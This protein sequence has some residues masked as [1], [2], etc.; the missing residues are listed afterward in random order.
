M[1]QVID[2]LS[3]M[4][5]TREDFRDIYADL[6]ILQD[7]ELLFSMPHTD[8]DFLTRHLPSK[9]WRMNNLYTIVDKFGTKIKFKMRRAQHIVYAESLRHPRLIILKSRQQGISTFW[10]I[11]FF[12][13]LITIKNLSIGLM[14]QGIDEAST[15]LD[16]TKILWSELDE[17]VKSFLGLS[18]VADN[19]KTF[20]LSN[21]S[22]IF[23][24]TSFRSTTL[25][26]LHISEMGKIANKFPEKAKETKTGTLQAIAQGNTAAIES[27]A[28]GDNLFKDMWDTAVTITDELSLK[29]FKPVFLSWLGDPD[30]RVKE[31]QTVTKIAQKYFDKLKEEHDIELDTEQKNFW[32]VQYRELGDR[33]YQEYP[34]TDIEAFMATKSGTY[35]AQLYMENV[36]KYKRK[37]KFAELYDPNLIIQVS[38]D[39]GMNDT[40]VLTI[41]QTYRDQ[42]RV[43]AE[44]YDSG[45]RISYYTDWLK[46]QPWFDNVKHVILPHDAEVTDLTSGETRKE[47]FEIELRYNKAGQLTDIDVTVL[48]KTKSINDDIEMVRNSLT[49]TW[50]AE[51]CEY[52][53]GCYL[54]YRKE[55]DEKRERFRDKPYHN[56]HSNG[57]DSIRYMVIGGNSGTLYL[58]PKPMHAQPRL[59]TGGGFQV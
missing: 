4:G 3:Y 38:V 14:A 51:D 26:R 49:N 24:R 48:E 20:K 29:D 56:E 1:L 53:E 28:E 43:L 23:I 39:L 25:Q 52:L 31:D 34:T 27:T 57:A 30:C 55:Y 10:L 36:V 45:Q 5:I 33:I 9:L 21:E 6:P 44:F 46:D 2:E 37:L 32:I 16:R 11:N 54:N 40:N 19:A 12:D 47:R 59:N 41:F 17:E 18:L 50:I 8:I 7:E 58:K 22:Q 15:L 13:D 42:V 35:Y